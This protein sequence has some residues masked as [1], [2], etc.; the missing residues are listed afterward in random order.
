MLAQLFLLSTLIAKR[1][2]EQKMETTSFMLA[3]KSLLKLI[4]FAISQVI[5]DE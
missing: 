2:L 3:S 1:D 5:D 4:K